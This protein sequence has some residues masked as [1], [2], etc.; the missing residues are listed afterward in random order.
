MSDKFH[1]F[2]E[3]ACILFVLLL[4]AVLFYNATHFVVVVKP[5]DTDVDPKLDKAFTL[6]DTKLA[7]LSVFPI[8]PVPTSAPR[9]YISQGDEEYGCW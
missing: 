7:S 3:W 1:V 8:A 6:E 2:F 5:I 4:M 9:Y